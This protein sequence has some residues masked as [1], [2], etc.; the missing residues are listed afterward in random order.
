MSRIAVQMRQDEALRL[1]EAGWTYR[2]IASHLGYTEDGTTSGI[3]WPSSAHSA[4]RSAR[5]RRGSTARKFG[6]EVEFNGCTKQAAIDALRAAGLDVRDEDY[7]HQTRSWWK[8][9]YDGSVRNTGT[10][11]AYGWE[12]VSPPLAGEAGREQ[13]RVAL[14]ALREAGARVD[15]TCGL[16]VH[17]D[18][19]DMTGE[20][21]AGFVQFYVHR[22][23][24]FDTLVSAS[25]RRNT[26]YAR[27]MSAQELDAVIASF[28][29]FRRAPADVHRYRTVNVQSFPKYG[30]IEIRQH[31]GTLNAR[32]VLAWIS[33]GQAAIQAVKDDVD[34]QIGASVHDMLDDLGPRLDDRNRQYLARRAAA[35]LTTTTA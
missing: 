21:I 25:R 33:L 28:T 24:A 18:M 32:K 3:P 16:H 31:Q 8:V 9:V 2:Q 12:L 15:R 10:G 11:G 30:T 19:V 34:E 23:D 26:G 1:R 13:V 35:T 29:T 20:E 17:H 7:N 4:V 22:Q 27:R 6:V 14:R 5:R